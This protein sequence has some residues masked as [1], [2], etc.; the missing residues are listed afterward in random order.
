M[1][2]ESEPAGFRG[3][4]AFDDGHAEITREL[5]SPDCAELV[6]ALGLVAAVLLNSQDDT[7]APAPSAQ[8]PQPA[9]AIPEPAP[10]PESSHSGSAGSRAD[11]WA[12]STGL[13]LSFDAGALPE[14]IVAP[15]L[16]LSVEYWPSRRWGAAFGVSA[17]APA[18]NVV[19]V[20]G[21][22]ATIGFAAARPE[23]C[24]VGRPSPHLGFAGCAS[25]ELGR[26]EGSSTASTGTQRESWFTPGALLRGELR[27]IRPLWI[28]AQGSLS[29]PLVRSDFFFSRPGS[30]DSRAPVY[31]VPAVALG[32]GVGLA[33]RFE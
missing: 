22:N 8:A 6:R 30:P 7:A 16:S 27:L 28:F 9:P 21:S 19:A 14:L 11:H 5:E 18:Q 1:R 10:K 24:L 32:A 25:F 17:S 20:E 3:K 12:V 4:L 29:F 13:A 33:V 2:I 15:R 31:A 26:L 23:G